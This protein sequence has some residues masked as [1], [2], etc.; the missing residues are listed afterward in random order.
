MGTL[1]R[2]K[3]F[4]NP[5]PPPPPLT[6][7]EELDELEEPDEDPECHFAELLEP[8]GL[9]PLECWGLSPV[10]QLVVVTFLW[11]MSMPSRREVR[12]LNRLCA[13]NVSIKRYADRILAV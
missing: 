2:Q 1:P 11:T 10:S 13:W 5:L 3:N 7:L 4:H 12:Q 9:A 8:L 6:L